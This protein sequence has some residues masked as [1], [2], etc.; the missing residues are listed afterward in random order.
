[1]H[2]KQGLTTRKV[3]KFI[4]ERFNIKYSE[5]QVREIIHKI[6]YSYKK[7]YLIYSKMPEDAPITLKL[8]KKSIKI[9][10]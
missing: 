2:N 8:N 5:K 4:E 6:D 10:L 1:M 3:H 9:F 7:R